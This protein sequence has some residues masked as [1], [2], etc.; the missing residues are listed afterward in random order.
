MSSSTLRLPSTIGFASYSARIKLSA[1]A[2]FVVANNTNIAVFFMINSYYVC[3]AS[4]YPTNH[5]KWRSHQ[6]EY[7]HHKQRY[8]QCPYSSDNLAPSIDQLLSRRDLSKSQMPQTATY[9]PLG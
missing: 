3:V 7:M 4:I 8:H 9:R 2:R 5:H 1:T 6:L